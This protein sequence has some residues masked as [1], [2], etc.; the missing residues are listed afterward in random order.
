[1]K[2][3]TGILVALLALGVGGASWVTQAQASGR[4]WV[5]EFDEQEIFFE[6]NS[7]DLDLGIQ[8]F[9]DATAWKH[10]FVVGPKGPLWLT[11]NGG[12]LRRLGSTEVATES[13]EP[14]LIPG[15]EPGD[16]FDPDELEK[17]V[18]EFLDQFPEGHYTFYGWTIDGKI[19][20][21]QTELTHDLL[22]PPEL[23]ISQFPTVTWE[24]DPDAVRYEIVVEADVVTVVDG[25]EEESTFVNGATL[26]PEQNQF[27]ASQ[28]F[29]DMLEDFED[30]GAEVS[31][32][33]ELICQEE[34]GNKTIT[35][36]EL[37]DE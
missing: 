20:F 4:P 10:V 33:V 36:E 31:V 26:G 7:T 29:L 22:D 27:T 28:E 3:R 15:Y 8:I 37:D 6:F 11:K 24:T 32:K 18:Q 14:T 9:Y 30:A 5:V 23:D 12:A 17:A 35:E 19:L 2:T 1:M 25:E 34:S 16:D 21:G 13:A